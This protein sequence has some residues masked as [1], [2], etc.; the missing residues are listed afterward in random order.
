VVLVGLLRDAPILDAVSTA[1]AS[2]GLS[3]IVSGSVS[4]GEAIAR[5][6][7]SR[8]H[9]V[10]FGRSDLP[11]TALLTSP[12]FSIMM[13]AL[14]R[15][16]DHIILDAGMLDDERLQLAAIAPRCVLI[17]QGKDGPAAAVLDRLAAAGFADIAIMTGSEMANPSD[18]RAAA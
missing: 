12:R 2:P 7:L 16:Y 15:A 9:L 6:K 18:R 14:Q 13:E 5:D 8:V 11:L 17:V 10:G 1:P 4:F 3:E